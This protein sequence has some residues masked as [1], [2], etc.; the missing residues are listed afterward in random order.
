MITPDDLRTTLQAA[1]PGAAVEVFDLTGTQDHFQVTIAA[2]EFEGKSR[3][4]Q[5]QLVYG[6]LG[7]R[8]QSDIHALALK[9]M[10]PESQKKK[11]E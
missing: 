8:M 1:F 3:I 5:H 4:E 9:T 10:I 11:G 7:P 6:A 2:S